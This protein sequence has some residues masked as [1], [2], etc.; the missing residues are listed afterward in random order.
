MTA[1]R[2]FVTGGASGIGRAIVE[3]FHANGDMVA[4][5]DIDGTVAAP[6]G[7]QAYTL[8]V[9][10]V[11]AL[12]S[13]VESLIAEWG[14]I[15]ILINN[16][17]VSFFKP[18]TE[19]AVEQFQRVLDINLRT[20]FVT[21]RLLAIHREG[22]A[23]ANPYGGRVINIS[24]TRYL[25]SEDG[26]EAYAAS[27]GGISSLT[28]ALAVSLGKYGITVNAIS[29]GWIQTSGYDELTTADHA[30]HPAGR[31]GR[32]EDISRTCLFLCEDSNN[33]ITAENIV[34][35]GGMTRKMIY[36]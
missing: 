23:V 24:S 19:I 14:D 18:I 33:F 1:R 20:A 35:D 32:V 16:V 8:D 12:T 34:I 5:C 27:K 7:V 22:L 2:V 29:P 10:D 31:V 36:D 4:Y 3:C 11:A 26:S 13:C 6:E 9:A 17:G 15:D 30:Q 28:H 25:M 21:A